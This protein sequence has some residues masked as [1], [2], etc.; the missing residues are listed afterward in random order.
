MQQH[1]YQR[2][3]YDFIMATPFCGLFIDMGLGK[4]ITSLTAAVDLLMNFEVSRVLIIAPRR[5]ARKTWPDEILA[6]EHTCMFEFQVI[7]GSV[8]QRLEAIKNPCSIHIVS[9]DN[10]EWLTEQWRQRWPYDMV[11]IDES[12]SFKDHTTKRFKAM[13]RVR[14]YIKRLV[15]LT[16]TPAA[17]TYEHL[18][19]QVYLLDS[20]ARFGKSITVYREQYFNYNRWTFKY[21]LR[22]GSEQQILEK[23]A[24]ICLVMRAED[25]L[26]LKQ[27]VY[28][29]RKVKLDRKQSKLYAE[30]AENFIV[31][32]YGADE[33]PVMV[34][35]ETAASLS[36]KLLQMSSGVLYNTY[37]DGINEK[38]GKPIQKRDIYEI[39]T[40]KL[41]MLEEIIEECAGE[42]ILVAYHF[43]SSLDRLKKRFPKAVQMD[44]EGE[45][46]TKWNQGKIS[47]LLAHP[48]SAGHGLNL[49]KGGHIIVYYDIPHSLEL[50]MQFNGRLARQGQTHVVKIIHLIAEGEKQDKRG[51]WVPMPTVDVGVVES[52]QAKKDG[53]E[54]LLEE[55]LRIRRRRA[56]ARRK[57]LAAAVEDF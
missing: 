56:N 21:K 26:D 6:W 44:K 29:N 15:E 32:V 51:E 33:Q 30:M 37:L 7:D 46:V 13:R 55:L 23:I 47:L 39:H 57:A 34:E 28:I 9:R 18:F 17:E 31:E 25:Y 42:N 19:A 24:D 5:V 43:Q 41:D 38:T 53:Q 54:W 35:A 20:G 52:L 40:A 4:T 11:I 12:S 10:V 1:K 14:P 22:E 45:C 8:K 48:Q 49:Q 50:Y 27:P 3:A 2:E 36:A 16:A